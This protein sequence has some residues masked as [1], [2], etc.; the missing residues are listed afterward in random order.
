MKP[1]TSLGTRS[2]VGMAKPSPAVRQAGNIWHLLVIRRVCRRSLPSACTHVK[3]RCRCRVI[4]NARFHERIAGQL[5]RRDVVEK[6][7]YPSKMT[8]GVVPES[9]VMNQ[10]GIRKELPLIIIHF[11]GEA[12]RAP[13]LKAVKN[14]LRRIVLVPREHRI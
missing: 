4:Q 1:S 9:G 10:A 8:M 2:N 3:Y 14:R 5:P 7:V 6:P 12:P 13:G 11:P